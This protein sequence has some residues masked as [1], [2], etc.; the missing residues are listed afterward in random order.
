LKLYDS[1]RNIKSHLIEEKDF[2]R[3]EAD[4]LS[5]KW[6]EN[7]R[8]VYLDIGMKEQEKNFILR[9]DRE[10][11]VLT[12][13]K[14]PSGPENAIVFQEFS[15]N[16]YYLDNFGWLFKEDSKINKVAF[17]VK[18]ETEYKLRIFPD[19]IFLAEEKNLYLLNS[20]SGSFEKFFEDI[21]DLKISPDKKKITFF[22]NSEIW[23][24]FLKDISSQ[25]AK[26]AG[27]KLFLVRLSEKIEDVFWLNSNYLIFSAGDK[28]KIAEIDERDRTQTWEI[29][30][31]P[32]PRIFWNKNDKKLY[33]LSGG[34]LFVSKPLLP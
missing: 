10:P 21:K 18:Q 17:Q 19:Y 16:V 15:N 22:S 13:R 25:P 23:V 12:E 31:F 6:A 8:E 1:E 11:P 29:G 5:L 9:L 28:I 2:T 7:S 30:E 3:F 34:N 20:E 14:I 33:I 26:K 24:L 32:E 4:L 27:E